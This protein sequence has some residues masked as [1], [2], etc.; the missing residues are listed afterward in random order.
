MSKQRLE[1]FS[2]GVF[3]IAITLL[4]LTIA[5]P[6]NFHDL[7][8]DLV[9]RLP[10]FAAYAVSFVVIGIMWFNHHSIFVHFA[11]VDR[12]LVYLNLL[13]LLTVAFIPYPTEV[14][15]EALR[16]GHGAQVAAVVYSVTMAVNA[17]V[18]TALWIYASRG[19]RLLGDSFPEAQRRPATFLFSVGVVAYTV[20]IGI[21][22]IN[23][24]GCLAFHALLAV[25]YALD[26]VSRRAERRV[27]RAA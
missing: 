25:Y 1:S 3:A 16:Q 17:Y 12:G 7:G 13:L 14:F 9:N 11:R 2:D 6:T 22:F 21:A 23:A 15:G 4:I 24:F 26:P 18:W 20:S 10:S 27:R 5:Q 8:G 19:R